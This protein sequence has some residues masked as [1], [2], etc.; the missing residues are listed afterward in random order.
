MGKNIC[1]IC[2]TQ[3]GFLDSKYKIA[4]SE[5]I[6][7]QCM[8]KAGGINQISA[9]K[10]MTADTIKKQIKEL[11]EK[12]EE[13]KEKI[14][15]FKTTKQIQQYLYIDEEKQQWVIPKGVFAKKIENSTIYEYSD[16]IDF[17]LME[18]GNTVSKGGLGRAVAGGLLFGG[19]GAIVGGVTGG[20]KAKQT[21]TSLRIKITINDLRNPVIYISFITAEVKKQSILY[22]SA[23]HTAQEVMSMLQV[24]C[25]TKKINQF[26]EIKEKNNK[27]ETEDVNVADEIKKFK[28]LLDMEAITQEE[29]DYK[30][31]ELLKL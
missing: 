1:G 24:M 13:R 26:N 6:C 17:E 11:E 3:L 28:E 16:I 9:M 19:V 5:I 21:C 25:E 18:D 8:T 4:D 2:N 29:F 23:Y 12:E 31:K 30:K 10:N 7:V 27:K 22:T 20:K 14:K 15:N